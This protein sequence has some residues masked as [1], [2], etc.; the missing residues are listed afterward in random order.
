[1]ESP[2]RAPVKAATASSTPASRLEWTRFI[3]CNSQL[4]QCFLSTATK[5]FGEAPERSGGA[6]AVCSSVRGADRLTWLQGLLTNDVLAL[7]VGGV[8][9]AAYLTPQGRMI[10]DMRV[11]NG[12]DGVLLDVPASLAASL[13]AKLDGLLFAEDAQYC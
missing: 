2:G 9:D 13:R 12:P 1:M 10:A 8:C 5:P 4:T 3:N 7:P 6:I 11:V